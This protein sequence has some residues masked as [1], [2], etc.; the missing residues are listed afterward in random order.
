VR[1]LERANLPQLPVVEGGQL[2]GAL[3]LEDVMRGMQLQQVLVPGKRDWRGP[4]QREA[5]V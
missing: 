3:R 1:A 4:G 2:V 5:H